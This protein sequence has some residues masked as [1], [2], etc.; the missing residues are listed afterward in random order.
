[1]KLFYTPLEKE[2]LAIQHP[3]TLALNGFLWNQA[4][5]MHKRMW[6]EAQAKQALSTKD[7]KLLKHLS[8]LLKL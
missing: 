2:L 7:A 1:M 6:K 5:A 3:R 8:M 4:Y